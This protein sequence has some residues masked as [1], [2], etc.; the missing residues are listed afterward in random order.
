MSLQQHFTDDGGRQIDWGRTSADYAEHR[1]DYPTEFY[2]RLAKRGVGLAGQ[3]ILDLGTGV[4]FLAE[5]FTRRGAIVTGIDIA[6]GQVAVARQ[7]AAKAGLTIDYRAAPAEETG[8]PTDSFDV[9]TASQCW[10]YFDKPRAT[11]EARRVLRP[12]GL[13]VISHLCWLTR[14]SELARQAEELALKYNPG[15]TGARSSTNE[16]VE[17]PEHFAGQF[18]QLESFMFDAPMP[19]TRESWLGRWRACRGVGAT[20]SPEEIAAFDREHCGLLDRMVG[21]QFTVPH[22]IDC[23]ILRRV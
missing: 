11:A 21:D 10:H 2:E 18:E 19:F 17:M 5:N 12:A 8:L 14:Q 22:R 13:L 9:V 16:P 20:L 1:P 4:G 3:R 6:E 23:R 15:W 7:R